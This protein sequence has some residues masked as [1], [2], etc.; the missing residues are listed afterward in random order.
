M[1]KE[2]R[3][4]V[5]MLSWSGRQSTEANHEHSRTRAYHRYV[6]ISAGVGF[7]HESFPHG[8]LFSTLTPLDLRPRKSGAVRWSVQFLTYQAILMAYD[9][10]AALKDR[11]AQARETLVAMFP[12][13]RRPG[14]TYQGFIRALQQLPAALIEQVMDHLRA[15]HRR[16][17]QD[18]WK[19]WGW[20]PFA[21]DGSR[22]EV[23]R[24]RRN[25]KA[26]GCAGRKKTGPQLALTTL[27][28]MGTGLPWDW[29]IGAGTEAERGHLRCMLPSLPWGAL[30]V[31]D[32]GFT[33]YDLLATMLK[34]GLSF[35]I[36]VGSN[37]TL[38]KDLGL[39]VVQEKDT[40]WLWPQGKRDRPPL[41]LRLIRL[42]GRSLGQGGMC[43]VTDVFDQGALSD[44]RAAQLYR[45]RW[46]VEVFYRSFKQTFAQRKMRSQAPEQ[47]R[48]ELRWAL[49]AYLLLGLMSTEALMAEDRAPLELSMASALRVVRQSMGTSGAWRRGG[50]LRALLSRALKDSY[51][52][53]SCKK[54]RAWPHKK[55]ESPP[56]TPRIRRA[57]EHERLRAARV[58]RAA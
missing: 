20:I 14:K 52:R 4:S 28:H 1:G 3:A 29:R 26:L 13:R 18:H 53:Q 2:N 11:F 10:S 31:A 33:G 15:G 32:A 47:A 51:R 44:E 46:G 27:Y 48:C 45:L 5:P 34:Q 38:L 6:H 37:V 9:S 16:V 41:K 7:G 49:I 55:R 8:P 54:A 25:Q 57:T 58:Y 56:G 42:K 21:T 40:V 36:R 12:G 17:A 35:L 43:L 22:I 30:L 24:T 23:P 19:L 50:D 39:E